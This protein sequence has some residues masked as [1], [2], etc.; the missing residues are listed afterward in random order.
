LGY[1]FESL[2]VAEF[3]AARAA[4]E[5]GRDALPKRHASE[6]CVRVRDIDG[7]L[8]FTVEVTM[9][10]HRTVRALA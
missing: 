5:I 7:F 10:F 6:V 1:E 4:A 8:L 2:E 9:A 3:E